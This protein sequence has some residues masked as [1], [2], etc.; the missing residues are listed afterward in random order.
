MNFEYCVVKIV[1][2][3]KDD[4]LNHPLNTYG[5]SQSSGSGFYIDPGLILTCYH[6]IKNSLKIRVYV[7]KNNEIKRVRANIKYIF[8]TVPVLSFFHLSFF[9]RFLNYPQINNSADM[10]LNRR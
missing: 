9:I 6:V 2:N 1:V 3:K 10:T 4:D 7:Y 8:P 5:N